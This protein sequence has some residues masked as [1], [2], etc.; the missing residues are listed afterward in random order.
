MVKLFPKA[1]RIS[2]KT[3]LCKSKSKFLP[4]EL[5][6]EWNI[7]ND[8]FISHADRQS[9]LILHSAHNNTIRSLD[10]IYTTAD[11]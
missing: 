9:S 6:K 5:T 10:Y 1:I 3:A 2:K 4:P 7:E 8:M 11:R